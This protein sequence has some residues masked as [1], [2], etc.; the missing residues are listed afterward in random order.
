MLRKALWERSAGYCEVSG[1]A[2]DPDTFD[3]HHRRNKGMGGTTRPDRDSL[4]NLI[5]VDPAVH[6]AAGPGARSIHGSKTWSQPRGYLLW[7]TQGPLLTPM[8]YR[9]KQWVLLT[10]DGD[11]IEV[12][13]PEGVDLAPVF[14][15]PVKRG[16]YR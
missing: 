2:L 9:E 14:S 7:Q 10:A 15:S 3:A 13:E 11:F 8:H 1:I 6:N 4:Q 5:A 16:Q 12:D